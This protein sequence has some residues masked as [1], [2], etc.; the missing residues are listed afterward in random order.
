LAAH[1]AAAPHPEA[2]WPERRAAIDAIARVPPLYLTTIAVVAGDAIGSAGYAVP[3]WIAMALAIGAAIA[4]MRV[5]VAMGLGAA[6]F[7]IA[8]AATIPAHQLLHPLDGPESLARYADDAVVTVVGWMV[9]EPENPGG[10]RTYLYL[11]A[12]RAG[13]DPAHLM[14]AAG[15][16]RV[17][18]RGAA[19]YRVGDEVRVTARVRFPRND[20]NPGEFDY[21]AWMLRRRIV[22]TMFIEPP[23]HG[24]P[25]AIAT[26]GYRAVF[27]AAQIEAVREHFG[28]FIDANLGY[29]ASAEMRAIIIGDRGGI[30]EALR[31]RFALTGMAHLL[32]ISGLHLGIA[33][34]AAFFMVRL[35]MGLFPTLMARGYA[36]KVA[37]GSAAIAAMAYATIAGDHVSTMRALVM[38]IAYAI[39]IVIDRSRELM[40]SIALAALVICFA[41]PGSTADIGFQLSFVSVIAILLGMRRFAAWWRIRYAHPLAPVAARSRAGRVAEVVAGYVALSFWALVGTAPLTAFHFNQFS[42]V[43]IVANAIVVPIMGFGA[44][45]FGLAAAALSFVWIGGARAVLGLA[46]GCAAAGTRLAGW[47]L[48]WPLAWTRIFT[49]TMVEIALAY[50]LIALWISRPLADAEFQSHA[51]GAGRERARIG[52]IERARRWRWRVAGAIAIAIAIDAGYWTRRRLFNPDLRVTFLAVGQ[53]DGAVVRF[54]GS[55]VMVIDGGGAFGGTFDPGERIVAPYLWS[56]KIMH[57]DYVALS[58]P[59]RDHFGGLTFIVENFSPAEF[60]SGGVASDD[61]SYARLLD[62]VA[63]VDAREVL[64]DAAAPARTIGGVE[65]RCLWPAAKPHEAKDNNSS[66]VIRLSYRGRA[67]LFAGDLEARGER[68]L[69]ATGADLRAAILKAPHHG[70]ATSSSAALIAAVHPAAAVIS[71][72]WHNQF[73]FPAA[74]VIDRYRA[75]GVAV[76]RTDRLGAITVDVTGDGLAMRCYRGGRIAMPPDGTASALH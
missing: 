39:A 24:A 59:D 55:Q 23:R 22:A 44:V 8:A 3:I 9:R 26:I 15:L 30:D 37:A 42:I 27:P 32:V 45:I 12:E 14:P 63:R 38:V 40:S 18:V 60:W 13:S 51:A 61:Y 1:P 62:A 29:P 71:L 65:V 6:M 7:A 64:C 2:V 35:A 54:P 72:G 36:N 19:G 31:N 58:H 28:A 34:A 4:F 50:G 69:I 48:G 41:M 25:A 76:F 21:R 43:G 49:P 20:G 46:G 16:V 5:R 56:R 57:V 66:M 68:E 47:F 73:H 74:A 33:A 53:G 10:G 75:A 17:T 67:I 70:S 11:E 52:E